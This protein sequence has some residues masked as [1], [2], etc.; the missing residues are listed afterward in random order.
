MQRSGQSAATMSALR[1]PQSKPATTARS[2]P[3][4]SSSATASSATPPAH[5][6]GRVVLGEETRRP[7]AAQVGD[8][9]PV[10]GGGQERDH[11][12]V[13][14]DVVRPAVQQQ[15]HGTGGGPAVDV[16]HVEGAGRDL[17]DGAD[18]RFWSGPAGHLTPRPARERLGQPWRLLCWHDGTRHCA[19]SAPARSVTN[20]ARPTS[21]HHG[22]NFRTCY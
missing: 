14:V 12:G 21:V 16:A 5:R 18:Q 1:A 8:D 17:L 11:I 10:A 3:S 13:A 20:R 6:C 2:I 19:C 7:E 22:R 4:A 15:G 9:H